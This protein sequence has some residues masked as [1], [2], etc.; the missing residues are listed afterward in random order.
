VV[1]V[2]DADYWGS[3]EAFH[4]AMTRTAPEVAWRADDEGFEVT[5]R[6]PSRGEVQFSSLGP[7]LVD[8]EEV[9]ISGYPR[10]DNPWAQVERGA[11]VVDIRDELGCLTLDLARG[12]RG[13]DP[14]RPHRLTTSSWASI[15]RHPAAVRAYLVTAEEENQCHAAGWIRSCRETGR[16]PET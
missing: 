9:A 5:Y 3:F 6:S 7:L 13:L 1:E 14:E 16:L 11:T 10:F 15:F 8:G 2:G 12:R 4:L